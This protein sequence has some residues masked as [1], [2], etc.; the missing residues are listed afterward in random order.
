MQTLRRKIRQLG[1]TERGQAGAEYAL[2]LAFVALV[3][4][5]A[6]T[7]L[8]LAITGSIQNLVNSWP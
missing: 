2:V 3:A 6:L 7:A 5:A 4:T 1:G 8:G